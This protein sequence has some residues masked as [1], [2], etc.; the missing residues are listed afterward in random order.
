MHVHSFCIN[1]AYPSGDANAM[2]NDA[3]HLHL[4]TSSAFAFD[5]A[6]ALPPFFFS[7]QSAAAVQQPSQEQRAEEQKQKQNLMGFW[8]TA[9][10]RETTPG[11]ANPERL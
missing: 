2:R 11:K 3:L 9:C 6:S 5:F 4:R 7:L 8:S 1:Y 10:Q